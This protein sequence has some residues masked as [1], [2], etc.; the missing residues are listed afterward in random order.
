SAWVEG[1]VACYELL[2]IDPLSAVASALDLD[3]D[4][5]N[6]EFIR[7][8]DRLVQSLTTRG[9][10]VAMVDN[11]GHA[12][13]AKRRAKGASAKS[14]RADLTFSCTLSTNPVGLIVKAQKVRSV[15]A[16]FQRGD[17]WLFG[18]DT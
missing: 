11:V 15:R 2:A 3:F 12:E 9:V 7:F 14:D 6:A 1:I 10:A 16:G 8:Y 18:K 13:D 4:K 5:S 17:E